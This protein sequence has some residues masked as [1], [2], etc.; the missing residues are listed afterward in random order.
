CAWNRLVYHSDRIKIASVAN[1]R[2]ITPSASSP[3]SLMPAGTSTDCRRR[4]SGR[5]GSPRVT[6]PPFSDTLSGAADGDAELVRRHRSPDHEDVVAGVEP[7]VAHRGAAADRL[8]V[9]ETPEVAAAVA[10]D[11]PLAVDVEF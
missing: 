4:A 10:D 8:V 9:H 11:R 3:G 2:R 5:P 7:G 6:Q 1:F